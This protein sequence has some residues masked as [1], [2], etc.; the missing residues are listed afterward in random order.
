M[1]RFRRQVGRLIRH[2]RPVSRVQ[3]AMSRVGVNLSRVGY[4]V[5]PDPLLNFIV[6][7]ETHVE[8]S[9]CIGKGRIHILSL[10][11]SK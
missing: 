3:L 5:H 8:I 10:R 1:N 4:L 9:E 11:E 2:R 6:L 7:V